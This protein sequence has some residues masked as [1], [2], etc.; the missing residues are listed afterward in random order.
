MK[1]RGISQ[2][3]DF[4]YAVS[5][6]KGIVWLQSSDGSRFNLNSVLNQTF[7]LYRLLDAVSGSFEIVCS[8][9]DDE[10]YFEEYF[11]CHPEA[12]GE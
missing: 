4:V 10:Q 7:A 12:R 1:I 6:C 5:R 2:L 3:N 8:A 11:Q 9:S